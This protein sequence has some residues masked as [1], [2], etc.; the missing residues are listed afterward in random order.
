VHHTDDPTD[1]ELWE[2]AAAGRGAA[3]GE[4]FERHA[5]TI[6]NYCFRRTGDWALAEDLTSTVF[7]EA[8]RRRR[9]VILHENSLLP[10]LY[11]VATNLLRNVRRTLRRHRAALDRLPLGTGADPDIAEDV[12]GRLDDERR[13][14]GLLRTLRRMPKADLDVISLCVWQGLTYAQA[15]TALGVPVGT[16]RSR[17]ARARRRIRE[18]G[19]AAGHEQDEDDEALARAALAGEGQEER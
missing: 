12:A 18:L 6:Y 13:M 8:W 19:G 14:H 4:L 7:L 16:V 3:F 15:A 5:R 9:E 2:E 17:L 11:G 1:R 10:W